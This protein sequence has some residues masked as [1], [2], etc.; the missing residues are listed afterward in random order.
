MGGFNPIKPPDLDYVILLSQCRSLDY[1]GGGGGVKMPK[2]DYVI[3]ERPHRD[4]R[5]LDRVHDRVH[6][7]VLDRVLD[8]VH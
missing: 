3:C 2:N 4:D 5:L 8:R 7:R 1:G 6:D